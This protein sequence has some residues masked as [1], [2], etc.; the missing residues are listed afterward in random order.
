MGETKYQGRYFGNAGLP[1]TIGSGAY[2]A[3]CNR[4]SGIIE[5]LRIYGRTLTPDQS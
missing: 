2:C 3:S 1:F 5:D 4:W